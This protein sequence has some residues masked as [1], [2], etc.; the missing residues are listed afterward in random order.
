M[1]WKDGDGIIQREQFVPDAVKKQV[2]VSSGEIPAPN[3]FAEED[4]ATN[5]NL[6][7][8]NVKA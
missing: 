4:I 8:K 1:A 6:L 2:L 3:P 5:D 7:I